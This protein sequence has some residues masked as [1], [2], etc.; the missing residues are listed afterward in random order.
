MSGLRRGRKKTGPV[1]FAEL[2][3]RAVL[4][5]WIGGLVLAGLLLWAGTASL[6]GRF[7]MRAVNRILEEENVSYRLKSA[8]TG[9][10]GPMGTWYTLADREGVFFVFTLF[11]EGITI[12]CG[13]L[14]NPAGQVEELVPLSGHGAETIDR[15]PQGVIDVHIRRI[16][17]AF[18]RET[19]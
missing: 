18:G 8:M 16:E 2:K 19:R 12:P 7:L 3:D 17:A 13:A 1:F 9:G 6:R 15:I 10:K 5:G 11:R 4:A 14:V